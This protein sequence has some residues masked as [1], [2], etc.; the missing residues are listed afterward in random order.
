[1]L[2]SDNVAS[3]PPVQL[4]GVRTVFVNVGFYM[5]I[6]VVDSSSEAP[7]ALVKTP[8][9]CVQAQH[10]PNG[11]VL[12]N[13]RIKFLGVPPRRMCSEPISQ[14]AGCWLLAFCLPA[15]RGAPLAGERIAAASAP[16][17]CRPCQ[18]LCGRPRGPQPREQKTLGGACAAHIARKSIGFLLSVVKFCGAAVAAVRS[19][20]RARASTGPQRRGGTAA[21]RASL[22]VSIQVRRGG[23]G[24][25]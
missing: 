20:A 6:G 24:E 12:H 7:S 11:W 21:S 14:C 2:Q 1:M 22:A 8:Q 13:D 9:H 15:R 18:T 16:G 5:S 17:S 19:R 4:Y 3:H 25:Q 23:E 10:T